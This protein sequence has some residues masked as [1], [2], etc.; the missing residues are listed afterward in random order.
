MSDHGML[1]LG[2]PKAGSA[3]CGKPRGCTMTHDGCSYLRH[4]WKRA[5]VYGDETVRCQAAGVLDGVP[6]QCA[7]MNRHDGPCEPQA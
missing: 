7:L 5:V 2:N 1:V 3:C 6:V 4:P